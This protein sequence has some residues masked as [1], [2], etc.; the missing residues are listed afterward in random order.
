MKKMLKKINT[1]SFND[2]VDDLLFGGLFM[3]GIVTPILVIILKIV[4]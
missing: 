3:V 2:W 4:G 1:L